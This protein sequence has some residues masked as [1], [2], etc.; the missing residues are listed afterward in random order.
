MTSPIKPPTGP[1]PVLPEADPAAAAAPGGQAREAFRQAL[2]V[3]PQEA[4]QPVEGPGTVSPT[5][6][7]GAAMAEGSVDRASA[8]DALVAQTLASP[9]ASLLSPAGRVELEASLREALANDPGL[10]ALL[11]DLERS[12]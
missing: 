3:A 9:Q 11:D 6:Q 5:E 1:P 2:D 8:I 4:P 12:A 7:L 10:S